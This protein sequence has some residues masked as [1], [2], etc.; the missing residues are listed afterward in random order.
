MIEKKIDN[1][2][3]IFKENSKNNYLR[4]EWLNYKL[5]ECKDYEVGSG[6]FKFSSINYLNRQFSFKYFNKKCNSS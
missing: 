5:C 2:N 1:F 4:P 6:Q 3:S